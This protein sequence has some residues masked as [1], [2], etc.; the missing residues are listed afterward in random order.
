MDAPA[1][2]ANTTP[3]A[4]VRGGAG[5]A[6][7]SGSASEVP[8][9]TRDGTS[10]DHN[11]DGVGAAGGTIGVAES[12]RGVFDTGDIK[13]NDGSG[14]VRNTRD[15]VHG[16]AGMAGATY[17]TTF[18]ELRRFMFSRHMQF[19]EHVNSKGVVEMLRTMFGPTTRT[20]IQAD[21]IRAILLE[22]AY[23]EI[24]DATRVVRALNG[25]ISSSLLGSMSSPSLPSS[26]VSNR[27][28]ND[29]VKYLCRQEYKFEPKDDQV[30]D[31]DK[32]RFVERI[33]QI[34]QHIRAACD[35]NARVF[36]VASAV[37]ASAANMVNAVN[38]SA[39]STAASTASASTASTAAST[40][41][42]ANMASASSANAANASAANAA[43]IG[44]S[45]LVE[46][47]GVFNE[48]FATWLSHIAAAGLYRV[49]FA[50]DPFGDN[51]DVEFGPHHLTFY[52]NA[53]VHELQCR[54][55]S[56]NQIN[57]LIRDSLIRYH[58][59]HY[60]EPCGHMSMDAQRVCECGA[61]IEH[62]T[63]FLMYDNGKPTELKRYW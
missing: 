57:R 55:D 1:S 15:E 60:H 47:H 49:E 18:R 24:P 45:K 42:A 22:Y 50:M 4:D 12:G 11:V 58:G 16:L 23:D 7:G 38:A 14:D 32:Q 40:A 61:P 5:T 28:D 3:N 27:Y 21:M 30:V 46:L 56:A 17:V 33:R 10:I 35:H 29:T 41:S 36:R 9:R 34:I 44:T 6:E 62:I 8:S 39:A 25:I 26:P 2:P 52:P 19:F 59:T 53:V 20:S 13:G 63:V 51:H 31:G 54:V 43:N 37:N 48:W